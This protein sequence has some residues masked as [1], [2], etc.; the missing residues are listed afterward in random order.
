MKSIII[1]CSTDSFNPK[2][3][4]LA[5]SGDI[6]G[7]GHVVLFYDLTTGIVVYSGPTSGFRIGF[8][9]DTWIPVTDR[10]DWI[11]LAPDAAVRLSND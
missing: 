9:T 8:E 2:F 7:T 11:I 10:K 5:A 6:N 1:N 3:P 4:I